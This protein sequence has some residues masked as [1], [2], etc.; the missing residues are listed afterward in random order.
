MKKILFALLFSATL[1]HGQDMTHAVNQPGN[2]GRRT[3]SDT[4]D[5]FA[6]ISFTIGL[7]FPLN[8]YGTSAGSIQPTAVQA[9]AV[10]GM[11]ANILAGIFITSN[12][13]FV[14]SASLDI[15]GADEQLFSTSSFGGQAKGQFNAWQYLGGVRYQ[16]NLSDKTN[17]WAEVMAGYINIKF[18]SVSEY[19]KSYNY[20]YSLPGAN[21]LGYSIGT[22]IERKLNPVLGIAV[23]LSYASGEM[24]FS[25]TNLT[26]SGT[27]A[28]TSPAVMWFGCLHTTAG[29]VFHI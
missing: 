3:H 18:P 2:T 16:V 19:Y 4:V 27:Q 17:F 21:G 20:T 25:S 12:I 7:G 28:Q 22:G 5:K 29:V 15:N 26:G 10:T 1:C 9:Y 24:K 8:N 11:N 6:F 14:A 13:V 23:D